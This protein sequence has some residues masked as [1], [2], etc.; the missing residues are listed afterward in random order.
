[1]EKDGVCCMSVSLTV[2]ELFAYMR[3]YY[4]IILLYGKMHYAGDYVL[5]QV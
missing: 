2:P 4:D 5:R 1:M 3:T